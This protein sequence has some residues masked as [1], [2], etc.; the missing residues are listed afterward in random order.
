METTVW[1]AAIA[2]LLHAAHGPSMEEMLSG[3]VAEF[4]HGWKHQIIHGTLHSLVVSGGAAELQCVLQTLT[5]KE[6]HSDIKNMG[7][8][9]SSQYIDPDIINAKDESCR[10]VLHYACL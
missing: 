2:K 9:C 1:E 10:T 7:H 5:S 8:A 4:D 3:C 6:S